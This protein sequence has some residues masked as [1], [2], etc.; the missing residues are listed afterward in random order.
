M[1]KPVSLS[2]IDSALVNHSDSLSCL[3]ALEHFG[4]GRYG[5]AV[6]FD[7][8]IIG[9]NNMHTILRRGGKF[10]LSVPIGPQQIEFNAHRVF[11]LKYLLPLFG[12]KFEIDV[13]S[14]VNDK[15]NLFENVEL[16]ENEV[17]RNFGG[18]YGCGIF[19]MM[20]L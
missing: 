3:H 6:R 9:P 15:G 20:K 2:N 8:Y 7:G 14:F 1:L 10:Y 16:N 4:L 17:N 18:F 11:S 19:E 12:Q 13:F 5:D